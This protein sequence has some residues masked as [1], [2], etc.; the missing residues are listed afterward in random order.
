DGHPVAPPNSATMDH[1]G[2]RPDVDLMMFGHRAEDPRVAR[3]VAL[4]QSR[5]HAPLTRPAY[6]NLDSVSDRQNLSDP[7][8]LGESVR[9]RDWLDDEVRT[10]TSDVEASFGI[11]PPQTVEGRRCREMEDGAIEEPPG[12]H[13]VVR[14]H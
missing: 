8:V 1:G 6:S 3:Q 4:R 12:G 14:H 13:R 9:P 2:V 11:E 10:E 5:H 7:I